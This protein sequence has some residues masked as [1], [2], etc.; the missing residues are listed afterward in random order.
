VD[1]NFRMPIGLALLLAQLLVPVILQAQEVGYIDL[2]SVRQRTDLRHPPALPPSD[3][4]AGMT[5]TGPGWGGGSV[6]DGAPDYR[7][8]HALTVQIL[9]VVPDRI[10][11]VQPIEVEFRVLN[12]GRV[13][14][15][16]PVSPHVSDLQPPD[17]S[18]SFNYM[19]LALAVN[20]IV[21]DAQMQ[22][23]ANGPSFVEL[24]G[25]RE[26]PRT[27]LML[28]PGEWIRVRAKPNSRPRRVRSRRHG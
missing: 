19:S 16:L 3:C 24:Y 28:N 15:E 1:Y 2:T 18:R 17:E 23:I 10:D 7:D 8:P 12:S 14:L 26:D 11:P 4:K 9:S 25:S 20:M 21:G 5:C 6:T 22:P 13:P 27:M